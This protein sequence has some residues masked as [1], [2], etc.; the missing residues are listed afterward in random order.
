MRCAAVLDSACGVLNCS[1]VPVNERGKAACERFNDE[2]TI[3]D[4]RD[5]EASRLC[6]TGKGDGLECDIATR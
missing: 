5:V 2:L 6:P 1:L 4:I 3:E